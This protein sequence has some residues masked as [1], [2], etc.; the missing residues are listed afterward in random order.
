M[1]AWRGRGVGVWRA[2]PGSGGWRAECPTQLCFESCLSLHALISWSL[3]P[4]SRGHLQGSPVATCEKGLATQAPSS[5]RRGRGPPGR[6]G[7]LPPK[8]QFEVIS[9]RA[10]PGPEE[11]SWSQ[12][13]SSLAPERVMQPGAPSSAA[14]RLAHELWEAH[15]IKVTGSRP[16][17]GKNVSFPLSTQVAALTLTGSLLYRGG[18]CSG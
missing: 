2:G 3:S 4:T 8:F 13:S 6:C 15:E 11:L 9:R 10:A 16:M 1:G 17:S 12:R 14:F 7:W 18:G 5:V